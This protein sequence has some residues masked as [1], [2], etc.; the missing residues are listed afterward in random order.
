MPRAKY[1]AKVTNAASVGRRFRVLSDTLDKDVAKAVSDLGRQIQESYKRAAPKATGT[2][3]R[4]IRVRREGETGLIIT[5]SARAESGYDYAFI[6]RFG[7]RTRWIYPRRIWS[8]ST[9]KSGRRLPAM[10]KV[11]PHNGTWFY[12][13]RVR[14]YNPPGDWADAAWPVA[15]RLA[16]ARTEQLARQI[17]L[18]MFT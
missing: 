4:G 11:Q 5:V 12:A 2:L 6:T 14:G 3:Q 15:K 10:L 8:D 16:A 17:Q 18:R 7:H 1:E 9:T 13:A